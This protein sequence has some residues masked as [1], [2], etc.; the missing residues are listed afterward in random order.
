[1]Q[2]IP[3]ISQSSLEGHDLGVIEVTEAL[4]KPISLEY[5]RRHLYS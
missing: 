2:G 4:S 3:D 5:G 1:L